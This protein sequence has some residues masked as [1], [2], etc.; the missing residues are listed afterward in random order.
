VFDPK[1]ARIVTSPIRVS[2]PKRIVDFTVQNEGSIFLLHPH[3]QAAQDW[4]SE[5]IPADAQ[6]FGSAVV[7]E[8]RYICDIVDGIRAL[9]LEVSN[10]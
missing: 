9:S 1:G 5:H 4:V 3:T 2:S 7:I 10:D 8:H 6:R